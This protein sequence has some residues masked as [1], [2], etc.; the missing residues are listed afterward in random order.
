[1]RPIVGW[2]EEVPVPNHVFND[3]LNSRDGRLYFEDLDLTQLILGDHKDQG[4]GR[5]LPNPLEIVYLPKIREKIQRLY[6]IF[7]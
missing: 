1:M 4:L 5:T 2:E 7:D 6:S 3:Y